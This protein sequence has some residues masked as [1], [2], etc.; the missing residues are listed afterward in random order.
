LIGLGDVTSSGHE[1]GTSF[2][3]LPKLAWLEKLGLI[4]LIT[5]FH[6]VRERANL[7]QIEIRTERL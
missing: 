6:E 1:L 4:P 5:I 7:L 3:C 2:S